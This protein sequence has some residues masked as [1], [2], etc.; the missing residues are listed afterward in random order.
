MGI[1]AG[2]SMPGVS[3]CLTHFDLRLMMNI[4]LL[5]CCS[6]VNRLRYK[7]RAPSLIRIGVQNGLSGCWLLP[8]FYTIGTFL[9]LARR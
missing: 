6:E 5:L 8:R 4:A 9:L 2:F 7:L 1:V 3:I